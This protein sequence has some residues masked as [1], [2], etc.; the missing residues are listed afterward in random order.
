MLCCIK[1]A[2]YYELTEDDVV[3]TVLTDS[4]DMYRSRIQELDEMHG[5]Y[6][7]RRRASTTTSTCW[8]CGPTPWRS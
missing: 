7:A 6:D 4:A 2:K 3:S 5:P 8:A 1:M